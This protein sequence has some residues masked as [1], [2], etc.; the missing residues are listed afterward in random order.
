MDIEDVKIDER[1]ATNPKRVENRDILIPIL[2]NIFINKSVKEWIDL[3]REHEVPCAPVN[4]LD[5]AFGEPPVA[6]RDMVVKYDHP[7]AGEIKLPGNPM[8]FSDVNETISTPAPTLG[9]HT[10]EVLTSMLGM[11]AGQI[12]KLIKSEIIK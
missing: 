12:D 10:K 7:T 1:F 3:F 5:G 9:E 2:E 6:E 11:D 8:K 4:N